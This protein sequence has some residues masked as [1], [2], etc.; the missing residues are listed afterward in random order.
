MTREPPIR[1]RQHWFHTWHTGLATDSMD[2][3]FELIFADGHS[4]VVSALP[5]ELHNRP[6]EHVRRPPIRKQKSKYKSRKLI[7]DGPRKSVF[8][9]LNKHLFRIKPT[10]YLLFSERNGYVR[11]RIDFFGFTFIYDR[12]PE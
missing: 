4:E 7:W 6:I 12:R 9:N 10:K 8:L 2:Y 5:P 1:I 3:E 11:K